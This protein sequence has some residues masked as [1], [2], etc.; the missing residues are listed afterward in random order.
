MAELCVLRS[1]SL[2]FCLSRCAKDDRLSLWCYPLG[3][4]TGWTRERDAREWRTGMDTFM[5]KL[6]QKRN[7]QEIIRANAAA[8]AQKMEKLEKQVEAYEGILQEMRKVNTRSIENE[9][10]LER[11]LEES[12]KKIEEAQPQCTGAEEG[13]QSLAEEIRE[14]LTQT[15]SS[16]EE[17]LR[18]S[19][20]LLHRE[21]VKVYR[22]VQ[23]SLIE[24]LGKQTQ[25]W[26]ELFATE[27]KPGKHTGIYVLLV[28]ILAG[29]AANLVIALLPYIM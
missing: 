1:Q 9:H 11:L 12:L 18:Q 2:Y 16:M 10:K 6:A 21:N 23:A 3:D 26:K 4:G 25:E 7:A 27:L 5:D 19:D 8:E 28:L 17:Q 13:T 20:D 22:N 14:T 29:V 24:E 15:R